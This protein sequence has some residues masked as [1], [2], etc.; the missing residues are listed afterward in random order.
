MCREFEAG[1]LAS[2][3]LPG[4]QIWGTAMNF[5]GILSFGGTNFLVEA[6]CLE[7]VGGIQGKF[8]RTFLEPA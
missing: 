2:R 5:V 1:F 4:N 7:G 8:A 6:L 3:V